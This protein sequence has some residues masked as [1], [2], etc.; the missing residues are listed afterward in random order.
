MFVR[1]LT[2]INDV[3][4]EPVE[5]LEDVIAEDDVIHNAEKNKTITWYNILRVNSQGHLPPPPFN[6]NTPSKETPANPYL[7]LIS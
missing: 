4:D 2:N 3:E 7:W 6:D 1:Y 5:E